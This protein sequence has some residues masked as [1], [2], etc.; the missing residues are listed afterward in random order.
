MWRK[1]LLESGMIILDPDPGFYQ[2]GLMTAGRYLLDAKTEIFTEI[3]HI[4]EIT[5]FRTIKATIG[6]TAINDIAD[7]TN[8]HTHSL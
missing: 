1:F 4:K 2:V 8:I 3:M 6:I 7:I 5:D